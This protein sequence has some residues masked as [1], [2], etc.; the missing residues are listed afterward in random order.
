MTS[1]NHVTGAAASFPTLLPDRCEDGSSRAARSAAHTRH[2]HTKGRKYSPTYH[3]WQAMLAR[4]RYP[5]RDTEAKHGQR[6]IVVCARCEAFDDFLADMG[7]RPEGTT[8]ERVDND[9]SYSPGN[10]R[11]AT[12]T[13]QARNRRNSRLTLDTAVEVALARLSGEP[14]KSIAKRYGISESLPR[15]I[16]SGRTWKDAGAKARKIFEEGRRD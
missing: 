5:D 4:C 8:L 3:S 13:E 15:E 12:P 7:E 16:V 10:C 9:G 11:W 1:D 2:G 14:C 6:G